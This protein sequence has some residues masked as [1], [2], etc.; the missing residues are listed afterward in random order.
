MAAGGVSKP[1]GPAV[2]MTWHGAVAYAR[3]LAAR[4][5]LPYRLPDELER[6]KAAAGVDA[7]SYPWGDHF[8]PTWARVATSQYDVAQVVVD[9]Y[10]LDE[11]PYGLRGGAGNSRDFCLGL[12]TLAGPPIEG[13]RL[14]LE[15]APPEGDAYRSV[16]GG[17]WTAV[18]TYCRAA[19]RFA[20]RPGQRWSTAGLRVARSFR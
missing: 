14:V 20:S 10:P 7:R 12:W 16:R 4:T 19:A 17:A 5:G 8:D 3:W 15:P 18:P 2:L 6:E 11:S 13:S 1:R 9:A